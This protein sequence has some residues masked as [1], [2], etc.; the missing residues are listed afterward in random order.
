MEQTKVYLNGDIVDELA[1]CISVNDAGF[2]HGASAF[3]TLAAF[4]GRP[5]RIDR[6]LERLLDTVGLLGLRTD[7]TRET[8][9]TAVTDVLAANGLHDRARIRITLSGGDLRTGVPTSVVTASP[10]PEYPPA[11]YTQGIRVVIAPFK[12]VAGDPTFGYKTGCYFPRILARQEAARKGAVDALWFTAA[13]RLA[14]GCFTNVFLVKDGAL[15]TPARDSP[16]LPGVTR[17]AVLELAQTLNI[18]ADA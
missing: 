7:Q 16:V 1:A 3:T 13:N 17:E 14:E 2:L 4:N 10:L 12:Q 9:A 18:P 6:H 5:F 8:L 15:R 11:Y